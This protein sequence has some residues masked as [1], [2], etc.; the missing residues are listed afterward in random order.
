MD[1]NVERRLAT[2]CAV[3]LLVQV[4]M[5]GCTCNSKTDEE[6]SDLEG[7]PAIELVIPDDVP[8]QIELIDKEGVR[9]I[10][11]GRA[12]YSDAFRSGWE[13]FWRRYRRGE[14]NADDRS[15]QPNWVQ[16]YGI[17]GRGRFDGFTKCRDKVLQM[18]RSE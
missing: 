6:T 15:V 11:D 13:E 8:K 4:G 14:I 3:F 2:H 7:M 10:G 9:T 17:Q 1:T 18:S 12:M 5:L 16:G